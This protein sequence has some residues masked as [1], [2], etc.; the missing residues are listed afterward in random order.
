MGETFFNRS[1]RIM[2]LI[3]R[4]LERELLQTV[5]TILHSDLKLPYGTVTL[6]YVTCVLINEI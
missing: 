5:K 2:H 1:I 3:I 6:D 4:F